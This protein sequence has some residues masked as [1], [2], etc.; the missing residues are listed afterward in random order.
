M[1]AFELYLMDFKTGHPA[2]IGRTTDP[3]L[4]WQVRQHLA[5]T[6]REKLALLDNGGAEVAEEGSTSKKNQN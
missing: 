5:H 2:I 6:H 1:A 3:Y 4:I